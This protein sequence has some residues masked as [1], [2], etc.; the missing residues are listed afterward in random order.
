MPSEYTKIFEFNPYHQSNE[1]TF[2]V[3]ADFEC[4]IEKIDA[5]ENSPER[6]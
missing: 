1:T 4:L 5:C 2:V 6:R 3:Y